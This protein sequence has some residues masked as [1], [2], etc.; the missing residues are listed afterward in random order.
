MTMIIILV[1]VAVVIAF[2]LGIKFG[3]EVRGIYNG[4]NMGV[5]YH[6]SVEPCR[7]NH[8]EHSGQQEDRTSVGSFTCRYGYET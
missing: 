7:D 6:R 8:N 5:D 1:H 4:S 3:Y 2:V